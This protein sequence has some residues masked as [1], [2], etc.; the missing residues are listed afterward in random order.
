MRS[1]EDRYIHLS[2]R[3]SCQEAAEGGH[4][5]VGG[6]QSGGFDVLRRFD[7]IHFAD[8]ALTHDLLISCSNWEGGRSII[9]ESLLLL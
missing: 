1:V 6:A 9:T 7:S 2:S 5:G 3:T 4:E 8:T